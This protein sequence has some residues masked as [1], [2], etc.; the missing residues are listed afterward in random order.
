[1]NNLI[2]EK[3]KNIKKPENMGS[4]SKEDCIFL[5]KNINGLINEQGNEEREGYMKDGTHYSEMLPIESIPTKD[6]VDLFYSSLKGIS[7]EISRCVAYIS[8]L[9]IRERGEDVILVSLARGGTPIGVLIKRYL[10]EKYNLDAPHYSVS[11]VRGKG[12]DENAIAYILNKHNTDNIQFVDGWTGKGAINKEL[13]SSVKVFNDKY[14]VSLNPSLAVLADPS[15]S[16]EVCGTRKD[17]LIPSACLNATVSGLMSRT[18]QREDLIGK[19]DFHGAK[20][21]THL[22]E[23]DLS[24]YFVDEVSKHFK[25]YC[26]FKELVKGYVSNSGMKE[27]LKIKDMFGI[28]DINKIKPGV[29]ET[30]R[31]LLR[32]VPWK[33]LVNDMKNPDL[34][35]IL[36]LAK[37]K[38]VEIEVFKNMSYSCI[39]LIKEI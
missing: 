38:N 14:Q 25:D 24:N 12:F 9:I 20:Y 35:H 28:E 16:V 11:I 15:H 34:K 1:M 22:E 27:V 7:N 4:Y 31:V 13:N 30:T 39:G 23:Y 3:A 32:R 29:G 18:V 10:K 21:Y 17:F 33:I 5:L 19:D 36:L 26:E 2:N 6:Y 8:E 37:N